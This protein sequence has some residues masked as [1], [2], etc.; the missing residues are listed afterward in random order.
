MMLTQRETYDREACDAGHNEGNLLLQRK[1]KTSLIT[2]DQEG[3][4]SRT[5]PPCSYFSKL[6]NPESLQYDSSWAQ[7]G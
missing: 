5:E 1:S 7:I 4:L 3:A 2:L 6:L